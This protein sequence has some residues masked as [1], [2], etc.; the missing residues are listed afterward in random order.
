M[1]NKTLSLTLVLLS[2]P[3]WADP[4][5]INETRPLNAEGK[6]SINNL[7]GLIEVVA[8][9]R[10]EVRISGELG[11]GAEKLEI[12][13]DANAL[14]IEV[15]LPKKSRNDVEDSTLRLRVPAGA[16]LDLEGV[17]SDVVVQG[18]RGSLHAQSVSGD[19]SLS[20]DA[21]EI[22]AQT[23][24]GELSL[25]APKSK[26]ARISSISGDIRV[27]GARD[28]LR[29]ETVSGDIHV[30]AD[31]VSQLEMKSVSGDF[32]VSLGQTVAPKVVAE[33]MSG[34]IQIEMSG[35]PDALLS[36]HTFSGELQSDFGPRIPEDKKR[37]ET[38][39]GAGKGRID[40]NS[41]SGDIVLRKR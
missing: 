14:S 38:T 11:E 12:T 22:E 4:T 32:E 10:N 30:D 41:F 19:V 33:T 17:S 27:A 3:A 18:T 29:V 16:K 21:V 8:W 1:F 13:G 9:D 25:R 7:S 39:L 40:L 35:N 24:S 36:M 26:N 2:A 23:V 37:Y 31:A 34:E 28:R 20:V 6:L 5:P 15:K